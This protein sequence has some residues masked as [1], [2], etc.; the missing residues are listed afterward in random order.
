MNKQLQLVLEKKLE[1]QRLERDIRDLVT[2]ELLMEIFTHF[3]GFVS[4]NWSR[5]LRLHERGVL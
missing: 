1:V 4:V 3:P 2:P 5:L